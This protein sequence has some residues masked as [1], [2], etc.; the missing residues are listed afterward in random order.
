VQ[1]RH[2]V[3]GGIFSYLFMTIVV[4]HQGKYNQILLLIP[5]FKLDISVHCAIK[6]AEDT[7]GSFLAAATAD[8]KHECIFS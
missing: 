2:S 6:S 8:T 5:C 7:D 4:S 1:G 3:T